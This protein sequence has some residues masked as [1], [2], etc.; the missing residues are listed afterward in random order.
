LTSGGG[1]GGGDCWGFLKEI[2]NKTYIMAL[3]PR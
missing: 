1:G 3:I 2:V